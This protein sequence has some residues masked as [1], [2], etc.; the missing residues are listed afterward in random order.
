MLEE[1]KTYL[2]ID[3]SEDDTILALLIDAAKEYLLDAGVPEEAKEKAKYKLA[4]ML[5]VALNYE[6]RNPAASVEKLSF[7]L[8]SVI[9]QMKTG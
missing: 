9:L 2:R 1:I 5:L 6:N 3:G 4:V 8:E 7:S